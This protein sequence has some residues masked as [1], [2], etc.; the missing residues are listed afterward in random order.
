[1]MVESN[2]VQ[3]V[4]RA[5]DILDLLEK[6]GGTGA[7]SDI[8]TGTGLPLPTVHRLVRTLVGCGYLRQLPDRRYSLGSR[9]VPLG[10]TASS[11]LGELADPIL[12]TVAEA[13]GES[14]NLAV[15]SGMHAEY[16]W[17]APGR[18]SMR[19][20]TEVGRRV[21][22]HSTGVGKALLSLQPDDKVLTLLRRTGMPA[23]TAKTL[24]R[25]E[26][27]ITDLDL[28]RERG[29]AIDDEE[30]ELGV[31][32]VAVPIFESSPMAISVSG[33]SG[34]MHDEQISYS[35]A[36]LQRAAKQMRRAIRNPHG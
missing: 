35:V 33:P 28:I 13:V 2:S 34:R 17:Q 15:L 18:H 19:M 6:T 8:G 14:A 7:I 31:R 23:K 32:C 27:M 22:L 1:M 29:Y 5:L 21:P 12:R 10:M 11:R 25:P 20:F 36:A 9:L 26:T 3:S 16:V 4:A 24:I 30:M